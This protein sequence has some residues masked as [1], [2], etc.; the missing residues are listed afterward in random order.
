MS[1]GVEGSVRQVVRGEP[2]LGEVLED[3]P[4]EKGGGS[5]AQVLPVRGGTHGIRNRIWA[6]KYEL[7]RHGPSLWQPG[8]I[9]TSHALC[10]QSKKE[11]LEGRPWQVE[12]C[13]F[14][15]MDL[16]VEL[17]EAVEIVIVRE[18]HALAN[19]PF[20]K[21]PEI[22]L[23][24]GPESLHVREGNDVRV[25]RACRPAPCEQDTS[26]GEGAPATE[27]DPAIAQVRQ[28][29]RQRLQDLVLT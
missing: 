26:I 13:A 4:P 14:P 5:E 2:L 25:L 17:K 6:E 7:R 20:D 9:K 10:P 23:H 18:R 3:A 21:P 24:S 12:I 19:R 11:T 22:L 27:H 15:P 1:D 28:A 8:M 29:T 16:R